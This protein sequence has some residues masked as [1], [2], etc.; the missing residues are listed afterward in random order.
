VDQTKVEEERAF[1]VKVRQM[2]DLARRSYKVYG[3]VMVVRRTGEIILPFDPLP[4][5]TVQ[6]VEWP[7]DPDRQYFIILCLACRS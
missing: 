3:S 5:E 4:E 6:I 1:R 7:S 2:L